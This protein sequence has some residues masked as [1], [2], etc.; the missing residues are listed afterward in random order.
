MVFVTRWLF[1]AV[2]LCDVVEGRTVSKEESTLKGVWDGK[3]VR[4]VG[5]K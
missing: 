2:V 4:E 3:V 5:E 1:V